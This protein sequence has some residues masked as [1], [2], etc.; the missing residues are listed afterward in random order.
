MVT[1]TSPLT[2]LATAALG[3][4]LLAALAWSILG[5]VPT[6][7]DGEGILVKRGGHLFDAMAPTEG[8][9]LSVLPVGSAV[10]QGDTV[11]TLDD[12][13]KRQDLDHSI[14]MVREREQDRDRLAASF[15]SQI[16]LKDRITATQKANESK[17]AEAAEQRRD[18]YRNMLG[19]EQAIINQGVVSQRFVEETRQKAED[20][21]EDAR[22]A[23]ADILRN[24]AEAQ[25][26]HNLREQSLARAE[27]SISEARRHVDELKIALARETRITSPLDG[28]IIEVKSGSGTVVAA[29]R[30][31]VSIESSGTGLEVLLYVSPEQG[32]KI[33]P[34]M[35]VRVSPVTVKREQFGTLVGQ[36]ASITAY[37]VTSEGMLSEL[38]N[39]ELAA[40]FMAHGPPYEAHVTLKPDS[41]T[42]SGY[43]W[44][45]GRG[46]ATV[47]TSGTIVR[48]D[49]TVS[50]QRPISLLFPVL[51]R[52]S[53]A[54]R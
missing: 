6:W 53:M 1:L 52:T 14:Q 54:S 10:H 30:P 42:P 9:V 31:I 15:A 43:A 36:V 38:Q 16:A 5:S 12:A 51:E 21:D 24:E 27:E 29:G 45:A 20:A 13:V 19:R 49:V 3:V 33:V 37:P 44:S 48:A 40:Q 35:T 50:S 18:F 17:A 47:L 7:V 8:T 25:D 28:Q 46:P 4:L 39:R 2:W 11:A 26:L 23:R 22:H 41:L 32:K 34:G